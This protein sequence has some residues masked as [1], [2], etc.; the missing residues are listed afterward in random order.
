MTARLWRARRHFA[1]WSSGLLA[2]LPLRGG[3]DAEAAE[4][5]DAEVGPPDAC[6]ACAPPSPVPDASEASVAGILTCSGGLPSTQFTIQGVCGTQVPSQVPFGQVHTGATDGAFEALLF[7]CGGGVDGPPTCI[8]GRSTFTCPT[9]TI[10]PCFPP[11]PSVYE[12]PCSC[13]IDAAVR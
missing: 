3:A 6:D 12:Q 10:S 2:H 13:T 9:G 7:N 4:D 5:P 8:E 1:P 11:L